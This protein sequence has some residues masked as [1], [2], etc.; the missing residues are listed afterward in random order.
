MKLK[1]YPKYKD[2]GVPWLGDVPEHW[3]I[4]RL[5]YLTKINPPLDQNKKEPL[6]VSFVPMSRVRENYPWFTSE[7][8]IYSE[9]DKG[10]TSFIN[11]DIL[12]AK[13]TP[14]FENGK[15]GICRNLKNGIGFGS[16]EFYVIRMGNKLI[17]LFLYYLSITDNFRHF[18]IE[19]MQGSAGQKRVPTEFIKNLHIGYPNIAEQQQIARYLDWKTAQI[20]KFI[21]NKRRLIQLLKEQK[22]NIINQAVTKGINPNVEM[23]DS[24]VEWLGQIPAHWE[25]RKITNLFRKIGSGTTPNSANVDYYEGN[26]PWIISGDLTDGFLNATKKK[27]TAKALQDYPTL[28]I[29]PEDSLVIAM[30]GATIGKVSLTT[31]RA[32]TNQACCALSQPLNIVDMKF[33]LQ[34]FISIKPNLVKMGYG[35]GQ[36]NISQDTIKSLRLPIPPISEQQEIVTYIKKETTLIDKTIART[37][38]EIELIQEYRSRLVSDVVTG[39][40]DVRGIEIPDFEPVEA[41]LELEEDDESEGEE[42]DE[43]E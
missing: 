2:S 23:K 16:T 1:P 10:L 11:G 30:Y 5:K 4:I 17:P 14:C 13:I 31:I 12:I 43:D 39:K 3:E 25:V 6:T 24:G 29:Y 20:N 33:M 8:R 32:C 36:P 18:G 7:E 28:K 27:I 41:D 40:L 37:E 34:L 9:L 42:I 15:G 38:R 35:G 19:H 21:R 26:I 22:Q